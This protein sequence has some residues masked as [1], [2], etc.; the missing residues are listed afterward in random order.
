MKFIVFCLSLV[1]LSYL[2]SE[3]AFRIRRFKIESYL[4]FIYGLEFV[5]L[6]FFFGPQVANILSIS[7]LNDFDV[8]IHILLSCVGLLL[9]LQLRFSDI[10]ILAPSNYVI[11]ITQNIITFLVVSVFFFFSSYS[12]MTP[13]LSLMQCLLLSLSIGVASSCSTPKVVDSI[14]RKFKAHGRVSRML[15]Y[16]STIDSIPAVILFGLVV[17]LLHFNQFVGDAYISGWQWFLTSLFLGA[18][19]GFL[20]HVLFALRLSE[21]ERLA[22]MVALVVLLAGISTLLKLS[23]LFCGTVAGLTLTNLNLQSDK[24]YRSLAL[25][26]KPLYGLLLIISGSI[27]IPQLPLVLFSLLVFFSRYLGKVVGGKSAL[28]LA[29]VRL[30]YPARFGA[31]LITQG[32]VAI[33][34]ALDFYSLYPSELGSVLVTIVLTTFLFNGLASIFTVRS[35]IKTLGEG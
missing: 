15:R 29:N 5:L 17:S 3:R 26:E 14:S 4:F 6:G 21:N 30:D 34:I 12:F 10:K 11:A 33:A 7:V 25:S 28:S 16:V 2:L 23:A 27:W 9:G 22:M 20:F 24:I 19:L 13:K 32:G 35:F 31:A 1:L 18:V 8:L